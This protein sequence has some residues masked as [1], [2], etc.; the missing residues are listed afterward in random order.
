M[1][2]IRNVLLS[3]AAITTGLAFLAVPSS[4]GTDLHHQSS[5]S[6]HHVLS[7]GYHWESLVWGGLTRTYLVH[8]PSGRSL[9]GRP[10]IVV[11]HGAGDTASSTVAATDFEQAASRMG[12]DVVFLQGYRNTWNDL[13][14]NTPAEQANV[15]DI[16]FTNAVL[17]ALKPLTQYKVTRVALTGFSNGAL[18]VETLGCRLAGR[19]SLIVPVEGEL[20]T[21]V[22][23]TCRPSR[24]INVLEIHATAD[25]SIPYGGGT[26]AGVGGNVSVLSAPATAAEWARLDGCSLPPTTTT[27]SGVDLVRYSGCRAGVSV[28]LRTIVGG[29]HTWGTN[30][31]Q[32]VAATLGH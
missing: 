19:I 10:L 5:A 17:N 11:Y 6:S 31:G 20:G 14:G 28:R 16:G 21:A 3:A 9:V 13:A 7:V 32:L 29:S 4:R 15:D 18:M 24:P 25:S 26:F 1:I 27:G 22:S 30:I 23:A 8:V 12:D 2:R